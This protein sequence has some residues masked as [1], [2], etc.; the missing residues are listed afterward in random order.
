MLAMLFINA[1]S[2]QTVSPE[3]PPYPILTASTDN[4]DA[5]IGDFNDFNFGP[6][7]LQ[8]VS[9]HAA[10]IDNPEEV[11]LALQICLPEVSS[12]QL[13]KDAPGFA[14]FSM[15]APDAENEGDLL[16][17]LG[18][19]LKGEIDNDQVPFLFVDGSRD[20]MSVTRL[21][22]NIVVS[23]SEAG[24]QG[25]AIAGGSAKIIDFAAVDDRLDSF[26]VII[27]GEPQK[28]LAE[29]LVSGV[30]LLANPS[31][32][33]ILDIARAQIAKEAALRDFDQFS[34]LGAD[35]F[36]LG[37]GGDIG[38]QVG[39]S[40]SF[41]QTALEAI[42]GQGFWIVT[43]NGE[44]NSDSDGMTVV[45]VLDQI[46]DNND[47]RIVYQLEKAGAQAIVHVENGVNFV[48]YG[49]YVDGQFVPYQK[50]LLASPNIFG[51]LELSTQ[52]VNDLSQIPSHLAE[53]LELAVGTQVLA[54]SNP[55]TGEDLAIV[56]AIFGIDDK[57]SLTVVA[58]GHIQL[59]VDSAEN[60]EEVFNLQVDAEKLVQVEKIAS[61]ADFDPATYFEQGEVIDVENFHGAGPARLTIEG[62]KLLQSELSF[63]LG[64][65]IFN[66]SS[67][68]G[69]SEFR[70]EG[71]T[72]QNLAITG[73]SLVNINVENNDN[74]ADGYQCIIEFEVNNQGVKSRFSMVFGGNF[75]IRQN[76]LDFF[77]AH[78]P[79]DR[80]NSVFMMFSQN[81]GANLEDL[82]GFINKS[83]INSDEELKTVRLTNVGT[84]SRAI[85]RF[86]ILRM[87]AQG[88]HIDQSQVKISEIK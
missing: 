68:S 87:I 8:H 86:E 81:G 60:G 67:I 65:L 34:G 59:V 76:P 29:N 13:V 49:E 27:L 66:S 2:A 82:D 77:Y 73:M 64:G 58:D 4:C 57:V 25:E 46:Y 53:G 10:H 17:V 23:L 7:Y 78:N 9:V 24:L 36:K 61:M 44:A 79:G 33:D 63:N 88:E 18:I 75:F 42:N 69:Y 15:V 48:Y 26:A 54:V 1:C 30:D 6:L 37:S 12:V 52:I 38:G 20:A 84:F 51:G 31:G 39:E 80:I 43:Q 83:G 35:V 40:F 11:A 28:V 74:I 22:S 19:A 71:L 85:N 14:M 50:A 55:A 62:V 32:N 45:K 16:P 56:P 41:S 47:P 3:P 70:P 21:E 72:I 5:M